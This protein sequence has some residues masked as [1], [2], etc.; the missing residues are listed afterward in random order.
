MMKLVAVIVLDTII[1]R[2]AGSSPVTFKFQMTI[3][4][5]LIRKDIKNRLNFYISENEYKILKTIACNKLLP[6]STRLKAIHNI[7]F[8]NS[9]KTKIRNICVYTGRPR[10]VITKFGISRFVFRQFA[11]SGFITGLKRASW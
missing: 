9:T 3:L 6:L 10:G 8:Y 5:K 2:C 7:K 4:K 11:D 1:V